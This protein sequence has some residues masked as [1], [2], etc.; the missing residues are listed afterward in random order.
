MYPPPR[1]IG[2]KEFSLY[3]ASRSRTQ[4]R[5][6]LWKGLWFDDTNSFPIF[7]IPEDNNFLSQRQIP[8]LVKNHLLSK[9]RTKGIYSLPNI[10]SISGTNKWQ[11]EPFDIY[12]CPIG[13]NFVVSSPAN[14]DQISTLLR[15]QKLVENHDKCLTSHLRHSDFI[16]TK[17]QRSCD[18]GNW[19]KYSANIR[20]N[21]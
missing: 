15:R 2:L 10:A 6:Q 1:Q 11:Q 8:E 5:V 9:Q 13:T 20:Q 7:C 12:V 3:I 18:I 21:S 14:F 17:Y 19:S 4:Q 16:S